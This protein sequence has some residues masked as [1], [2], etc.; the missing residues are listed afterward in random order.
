MSFLYYVYYTLH[1]PPPTTTDLA[2]S[3]RLFWR[4]IFPYYFDTTLLC[5]SLINRNWKEQNVWA[6]AYICC[7]AH[8]V[9]ARGHHPNRRYRNIC[10]YF[11][12]LLC[13]SCYSETSILRSL[14]EHEKI[15]IIENFV[16]YNWINLVLIYFGSQKYFVKQNI[17]C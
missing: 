2:R 16:K 7:S 5:P 17:L 15:I 9:V 3:D 14:V 4:A 11:V 12:L 6:I 8:P 13:I 10:F 1:R